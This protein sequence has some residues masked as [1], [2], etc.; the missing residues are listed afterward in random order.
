MPGYSLAALENSNSPQSVAYNWLLEHPQLG[1]MPEWRM[2]QLFALVTFFYTFNGRGWSRIESANWLHYDVE[3]CEWGET[4]SGSNECDAQGRFLGLS[5]EGSEGFLG[6]GLPPEIGLLSSL[7]SLK[8]FTLEWQG[9]IADMLPPQLAHTPLNT[10]FLHRNEL[11]GSIPS[12]IGSIR[13]LANINLISNAIT[14]TLPTELGMLQRLQY[15]TLYD[16]K[17]TGPLPSELGLVTT[18]E[19]ILIDHTDMTGTVPAEIC[20]LPALRSLRPNCDNIPCP[21]DCNCTC[22]IAE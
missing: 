19:S 12:S 16:N 3:E 9:N 11:T 20:A 14:G 2:H 7:T 1:S 6:P 22:Q 15:L 10:I 17:L 5:V 18:L 8:L 13:N 4:N 21:V